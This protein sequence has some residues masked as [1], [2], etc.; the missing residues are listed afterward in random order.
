MSPIRLL[1]ACLLLLAAAAAQAGRTAG[2]A[3]KVFLV[4][5]FKALSLKIKFKANEPATVEV[6][7][8]GDSPLAVAVFDPAGARVA[9]DTRNT[10]RFLLRWTPAAEQLYTVKVANRGG[11][12]VNLRLKTN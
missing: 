7:G 5:G 11:V 8:D 12:P 2:P 6:I 9:I 3:G 10:D 4:Q 1:A